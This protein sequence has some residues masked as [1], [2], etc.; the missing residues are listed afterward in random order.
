I[1]TGLILV[2]L[3]GIFLVLKGIINIDIPID[4]GNTTDTQPPLPI[5]APIAPVAPAAPPKVDVPS[6]PPTRPTDYMVR[7][8]NRH[9]NGQ[10]TWHGILIRDH[11]RVVVITSRLVFTN[12][13]D[14]TTLSFNGQVY[15]TRFL[16]QDEK[17]GLVALHV[18]TNDAVALPAISLNDEPNL[19][20]DVSALVSTPQK[21]FVVV[22]QGYMTPRKTPAHGAVDWMLL[23]GD[24]PDTCIG[25]PVTHNNDVV[26]LVIGLNSLNRK[27]A[28]AASMYTLR[29]FVGFA[30]SNDRVSEIQ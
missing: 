17:M 11:N 30:T 6:P 26:G 15:Q 22:V 9:K 27:H 13:F 16:V 29:K 7:I 25:A 1:V 10:R 4:L 28:I 2:F 23:G 19:P 14:G 24:L 5:Y 8:T 21:D 20:P 18:Y 3:L 12:G